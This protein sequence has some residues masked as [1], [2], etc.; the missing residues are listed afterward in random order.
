MV[1]CL[2]HDSFIY[3]YMIHVYKH[4]YLHDITNNFKEDFCK[5]L[6]RLICL[7][8]F[9][10]SHLSISLQCLLSTVCWTAEVILWI[11]DLRFQVLDERSEDQKDQRSTGL[12]ENLMVFEARCIYLWL[13][14]KTKAWVMR[15]KARFDASRKQNLDTVLRDWKY[16]SRESSTW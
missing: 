16:S 6:W 5:V 2:M 7:C 1:C 8:V 4:T 11:S 13:L 14:L 12:Y 9:C 15:W 10:F 3:M